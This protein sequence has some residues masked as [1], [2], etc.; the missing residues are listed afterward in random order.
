[1]KLNLKTHR[2]VFKSKGLRTKNLQKSNRKQSSK[3]KILTK[4][5]K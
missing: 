4:S 1:M 5:N 2:V 3:A